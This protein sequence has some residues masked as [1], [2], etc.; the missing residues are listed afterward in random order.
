EEARKRAAIYLALGTLS[1]AELNAVQ[2]IFA[3]LNA[4]DRGIVVASRIAERARIGR[5]VIANALRKLESAGLIKT[6]SLGRKGTLIR[7]LNSGLVKELR[8]FE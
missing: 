8:P 4:D 2:H 3:G 1:H 7:V 6:T 5:S